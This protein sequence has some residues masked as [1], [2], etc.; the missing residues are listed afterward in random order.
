MCL[1]KDETIRKVT[2]TVLLYQFVGAL[3]IKGLCLWY[4]MHIH[5]L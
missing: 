2:T 1:L 4:I 5:T 3:Y